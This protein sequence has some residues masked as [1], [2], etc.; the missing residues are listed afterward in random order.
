MTLISTTVIRPLIQNK[1]G[2]SAL[3]LTC[4]SLPSLQFLVD[5]IHVLRAALD[6]TTNQ[7]SDD[8]EISIINIDAN[9]TENIMRKN[10]HI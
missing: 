6:I 2:F 5:P 1:L 8:I 9:I 10:N 3:K 7:V 4:Y